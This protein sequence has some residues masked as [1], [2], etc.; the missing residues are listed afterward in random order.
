MDMRYI[1]V[2]HN[3]LP[4]IRR[5]SSPDAIVKFFEALF[6]YQ[7]TQI[8][9]TNLEP[10]GMMAFDVIRPFLDEAAERYQRRCEVN[11][12]NG[13]KGALVKKLNKIADGEADWESIASQPQ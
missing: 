3:W 2:F 6:T 5:M 8:P 13:K 10:M 9:P 7:R 11:R 4:M 12:R 1:A